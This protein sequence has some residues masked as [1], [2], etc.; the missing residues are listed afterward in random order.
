MQECEPFFYNKGST[1]IEMSLE[2][3]D[4]PKISVDTDCVYYCP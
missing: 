4:T 2:N 1:Y 3:H